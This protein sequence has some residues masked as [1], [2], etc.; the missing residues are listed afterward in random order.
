MHVLYDLV[1]AHWALSLHEIE[2][3][4]MGREEGGDERKGSELIISKEIMINEREG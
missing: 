2:R 1:V 4:A 3:R